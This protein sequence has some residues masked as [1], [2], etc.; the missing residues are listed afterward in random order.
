MGN[1]V[2]IQRNAK[3][4]QQN[5]IVKTNQYY[6]NSK[7]NLEEQVRYQCRNVSEQE[8]EKKKRKYRKMDI[9]M[10]L[11]KINKT[12]RKCKNY[13]DI[14]KMKNWKRQSPQYKG[15]INKFLRNQNF[16]VLYCYILHMSALDVVDH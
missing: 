11:K 10:Y 16:K 1:I 14:G 7:E 13:R 8:K 6:R 5:K 4:Y 2:I 12:K 9:T 15:K 3:Q